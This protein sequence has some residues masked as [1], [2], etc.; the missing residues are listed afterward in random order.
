MKTVLVMYHAN[1]SDGFA[2]AAVAYEAFGRPKRDSEIFTNLNDVFI[3]PTDTTLVGET[4]RYVFWACQYGKTF[5]ENLDEILKNI[6]LASLEIAKVYIL[7]FSF[8][9]GQMIEA[10][11]ESKYWANPDEIE[12][13]RIILIDHHETA[14]DQFIN[15]G[16]PKIKVIFDMTR[17]GAVLTHRHFFPDSIT[18]SFL[19]FVQDRDLWQ[20]KLNGSKE[21]SAWL[22]LLEKDLQIWA[23]G[24]FTR[25]FA[26]QSCISQGTSLL[27]YE[28]VLVDRAI[29]AS[30]LIALCG[31]TLPATNSAVLQSDICNEMLKDE[32]HD[33]AACYYH[34]L[35]TGQIVWSIRSR[36]NSKITAKEIAERHGG[37]G[38]RNAAGFKTDILYLPVKL[39]DQPL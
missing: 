12:G 4:T 30:R 39:K 15:F 18:P 10:V 26:I 24:I 36:P 29:K 34:D 23:A 20:W 5:K 14:K 35:E 9:P 31:T 27:A 2:A 17:C 21:F 1:C 38:H 11:L 22:Q 13:D 19:E 33:V 3:G 37:G 8:S 6:C 7:D 28:K 25:S 16:S 32:S